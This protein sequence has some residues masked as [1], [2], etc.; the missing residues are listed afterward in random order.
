MSENPVYLSGLTSDLFVESPDF[1]AGRAAL[2]MDLLSFC[3]ACGCVV[4]RRDLHDAWHAALESRRQCKPEQAKPDQPLAA[5]AGEWARVCPELGDLIVGGTRYDGNCNAECAAAINAHIAALRRRAEEAEA[6][7][8]H[9]FRGYTDAKRTHVGLR[10]KYEQAREHSERL[11]GEVG[12]L[13]YQLAEAQRMH[14]AAVVERDAANAGKEEAEKSRDNYKDDFECWDKRLKDALD[15][16]RCP[17]CK[18]G[19]QVEAESSEC[20]CDSPICAR[21]ADKTL[22]EWALSLLA[23]RDAANAGREEAEKGMSDIWEAFKIAWTWLRTS[24]FTPPKS[25]GACGLPQGSCDSEC[26]AAAAWSKDYGKMKQ[27]AEGAATPPAVSAEKPC[28]TDIE[29]LLARHLPAWDHTQRRVVREFI[30]QH[31]LKVGTQT[32]PRDSMLEA[33]RWVVRDAD[34][35]PPE[36]LTAEYVRERWIDRLRAFLTPAVSA[37]KGGGE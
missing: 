33:I 13:T 31:V 25:C 26:M 1:G 18:C 6:K 35:K 16:C 5:N 9:N 4:Y 28:P 8:A 22:A 32:A 12:A 17:D 29:S 10:E 15:Q 7:A 20:G 3:T 37:E 11:R 21:P 2:A 14:A 34:Y 36:E 30:E 19:D 23:E 27:V 24:N